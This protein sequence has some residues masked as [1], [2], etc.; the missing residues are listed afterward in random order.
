MWLIILSDQLPI[1][2]LVGRYPANQPNRPRT[3]PTPLPLS[4]A[5]AFLARPSD[6]ASGCGLSPHF[7]GVSPCAGQVIHVFLTRPPLEAPPK[8]PLPSDLHVLRT[9]PAFVLSQDQTRHSGTSDASVEKHP[10]FE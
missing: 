2:A 4:R 8:G 5:K 6:Q 7:W 1:V 10:S 9:P 3:P